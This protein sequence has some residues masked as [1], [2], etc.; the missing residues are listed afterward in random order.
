MFQ[1]GNQGTEKLQADNLKHTDNSGRLLKTLKSRGKEAQSARTAELDG[2]RGLAALTVVFSHFGDLFPPSPL[3]LLWKVSPLS[4]LSAGRESVVI[5]FVLSGF[6]LHRMIAMSLPFRYLQYALR[7][8]VRIYGPYLAA[9]G[10]A[11]ICNYRLSRGARP[12]FSEWFNE[13]WPLP[14]SAGNIWQHIVF[15][16]EYDTT[17]F[18]GAFWSLVHEMRISVVFP[19]LLLLVKQRNATRYLAVSLSLITL[20]GILK[21]NLPHPNNLG[22][23]LHYAGLFVAGVYISEHQQRLASWF[24]ALSTRFTALFALAAFVL[25]C[26]GRFVSRLF[27]YGYGEF[28]DI[29]VGLGAAALTV[30]AFGSRSF[31][32]FLISRPIAWLGARSYTLYLVHGTVLLSLVN[33][34]NMQKPSLLLLPLYLILTLAITQLFYIMIERPM[35]LFSQRFTP[36][37][38]LQ[39][40]KEPEPQTLEIN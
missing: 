1:T 8:T 2:L 34:L 20:G 18:N 28:L 23:S 13:A 33:V 4:I 25:F 15:L 29:P 24:R 11:V 31:S 3:T 37:R 30:M 7:R 35:V 39:L 17:P 38:R 5:F 19:L 14:V 16:G 22:E 26:Y 32:A 21:P 27:P 6:A 36:N 10:L 40:A 12:N 9:L